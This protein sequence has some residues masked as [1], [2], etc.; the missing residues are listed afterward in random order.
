MIEAVISHYGFANP[1]GQ[2]PIRL[3]QI[4]RLV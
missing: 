3:T 1:L 2:G 4:D